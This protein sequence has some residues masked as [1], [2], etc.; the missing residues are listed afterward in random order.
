MDRFRTYILQV[1]YNC[2]IDDSL[3]LPLPE[4]LE[5]AV[6]YVLARCWWMNADPLATLHTFTSATVM[7]YF[8]AAFSKIG[9]SGIVNLTTFVNARTRSMQYIENVY[10]FY[11]QSVSSGSS[12]ELDQLED[13][14]DKY[15]WD[16]DLGQP[17]ST[18]IYY[19]DQGTI[20]SDP[21]YF[22]S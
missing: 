15:F 19:I 17:R 6:T 5:Q 8:S 12:F 4:E 7:T 20:S 2:I 22:G 3:S 13:I 1:F 10:D 21:E 16:S 18:G 14:L 11:P 9:Y